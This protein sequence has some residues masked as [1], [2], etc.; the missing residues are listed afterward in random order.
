MSEQERHLSTSRRVLLGVT[1]TV[2]HVVHRARQWL[3][4]LDDGVEAKN[5]AADLAGDEDYLRHVRGQIAEAQNGKFPPVESFED[6][7]KRAGV[8]L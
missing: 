2:D 3:L 4:K 8:T 7:A 5:F 1:D 6:S